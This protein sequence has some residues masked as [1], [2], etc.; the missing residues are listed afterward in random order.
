VPSTYLDQT[1][2]RRFRL[3]SGGKDELFVDRWYS[4]AALERLTAGMEK[5][6]L[7]TAV[8]KLI[9]SS[10]FHEYASSA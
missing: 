8:S 9:Y 5:F 3:G 6:W 10:P 7:R 4:A 1:P 2:E